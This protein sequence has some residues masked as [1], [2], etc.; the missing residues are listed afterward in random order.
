[1]VSPVWE[2]RRASRG[3]G[4]VALARPRSYETQLNPVIALLDIRFCHLVLTLVL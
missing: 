2:I 4:G 3:G 1:V